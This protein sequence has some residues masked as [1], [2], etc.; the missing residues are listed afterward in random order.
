MMAPI[1]LSLIGAIISN[2]YLNFSS[3]RKF[4]PLGCLC[5]LNIIFVKYVTTFRAEFWRMMWIFRLPATFVTT[6]QRGSLRL[7]CSTLHTEFPLIYSSTATGP[8]LLGSRLCFST[9]HTEFP[10]IAGATAAGPGICLI[11]ST[12]STGRIG[13]ISRRISRCRRSILSPALAVHGK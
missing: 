9:F 11:S 8:S 7:L 12:P 4:I 6:V 2:I 10:G 3:M 1:Y 13:C 5:L